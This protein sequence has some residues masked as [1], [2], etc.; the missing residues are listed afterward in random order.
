[1]QHIGRIATPKLV[2]RNCL[3]YLQTILIWQEGDWS[4]NLCEV[5][6]LLH[7]RP[8]KNDKCFTGFSRGSRSEVFCKNAVLWNFYEPH[9]LNT[10]WKVSEYGVFS[11][12]FFPAFGLNTEGYWI[13]RVSPYSV[14]MWENTD[15]KKLRIWTLFTQ[16]KFIKVF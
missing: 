16:W 6:W 4:Q 7:S 14:R 10:A 8:C 2:S 15:Q 1:M 9:F 11:C 13:L 12:P 5:L 3:R